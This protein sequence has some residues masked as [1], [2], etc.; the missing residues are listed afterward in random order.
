MSLWSQRRK[1][2]YAAVAILVILI[3]IVLIGYSY[4]HR[5]PTC[6][7]G[8]KNADEQGVDCGGA[9]LKLCD[10][11]TIPPIIRWQRF[12]RVS[13]GLY[14]TLAYVEN[15]NQEAGIRSISYLFRLY[16]VDGAVVAKRVGTTYLPPKKISPIFEGAID[17]GHREAV[18]VTFEWTED[19]VW[20]KY[21]KKEPAISLSDTQISNV[22][23]LPHL[24]VRA[25]NLSVGR[26]P[27]VDFIAIVYDEKG[28]AMAFSRTVVEK[29]DRDMPQN[30]VFTWREPFPL[31]VSKIE[32][33]PRINF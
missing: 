5:S 15:S 28:N 33:I 24:D 6:F 32:V 21:S 17:T 12:S 10:F 27:H 7:D 9:C 18:R 25:Q 1:F 22:D 3:P 29:M 26:I 14:N 11:Q 19:Y 20:E 2:E 16:D 23:T 31:A 8:K 13:A 30:L 4:F